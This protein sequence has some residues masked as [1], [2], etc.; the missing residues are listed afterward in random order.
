MIVNVTL[1]SGP[2]LVVGKKS[3]GSVTF[4]NNGSHNMYLGDS[5]VSSG[6]G[7]PITI[8]G[9]Y[10][11]TGGW[12]YDYYAVGTQGDVITADLH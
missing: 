5:T 11:I 1:G 6:T 10:T 2:T 12:S 3:A 8:G 4:A 7:V 9:S